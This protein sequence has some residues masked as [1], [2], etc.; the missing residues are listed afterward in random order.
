MKI[1]FG[2]NIY[3]EAMRGIDVGF[4]VVTFNADSF[5]EFV[6]IYT[7]A[8]KNGCDVLIQCKGEKDSAGCEVDQNND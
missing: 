8:M 5:D 4:D 2:P 3:T 6:D 1:S 7:L